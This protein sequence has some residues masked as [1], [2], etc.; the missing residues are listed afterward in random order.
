MPRTYDT[1]STKRSSVVLRKMASAFKA[2]TFGPA[3]SAVDVRYDATVE[4]DA[5]CHARGVGFAVAVGLALVSIVS[6]TLIATFGG[7]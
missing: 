4:P 5:L 1:R 6:I 3:A 2:P 7:I